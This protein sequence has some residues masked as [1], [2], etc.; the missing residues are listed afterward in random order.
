VTISLSLRAVALKL[1]TAVPKNPSTKGTC[2]P[3]TFTHHSE[4]YL[5]NLF[6][7]KSL[8][9]PN[10]ALG[11]SHRRQVLTRFRVSVGS[12]PL[13]CVPCIYSHLA[14]VVCRV[15]PQPRRLLLEQPDWTCYWSY[16]TCATSSLLMAGIPSSSAAFRLW[17]RTLV[18]VSLD[19]TSQQFRCAL[20]EVV[21]P[22]F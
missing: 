20:A 17:K 15:I 1:L 5:Q 13:F 16:C 10:R 18:K 22:S 4:C 21:S 19:L 12:T 3:P 11:Y 9:T 2:L 14:D 8:K 6:F 7:Y